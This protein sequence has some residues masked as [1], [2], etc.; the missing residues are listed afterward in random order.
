[1]FQEKFLKMVSCKNTTVF[2]VDRAKRQQC[3]AGG[4]CLGNNPLNFSNPRGKAKRVWQ[5]AR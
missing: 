2:A 1:M 5:Q 4:Q 3:I